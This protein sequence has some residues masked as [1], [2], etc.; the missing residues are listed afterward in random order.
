MKANNLL[1][2]IDRT[3]M[4]FLFIWISFLA[5]VVTEQWRS[6]FIILP[7]AFLILS[8]LFNKEAYRSIFNKAQIPFLAF[9]LSMMAG[10]V[11]VKDP[12]IAHWNFW[13][14]IFPIPFFYLFAK[15][16]FDEKKGLFIIRSVC[17][18]ATLVCAFGIIE[19]VT[20]RN[21]IYELY[22]IH[23]A[24]I[25]ETYYNVFKGRRMMSTH[26]QPAPLGTYLVAILPLAIGLIIRE[27]KRIFK[28][29]A[30][31]CMAVIF[32]S[33]VFTFSRGA[34]LGAFT[35]MSVIA[36]FLAGRKKR[37]FIL[38]L[39]LSVLAIIWGCS[40][41]SGKGYSPFFNR[42]SPQG[43]A[44]KYSFAGKIDR[45]K[46]TGKIL[47]EYPLCGA[48]FGNYRALFDKY[49]PRLA[50]LPNDLKIPD[51]MY[52]AILAETGLIGFGGFSIFIYFLF[53][54]IRSKLRE[55]P[56][57]ENRM[58][59]VIFLSGFLGIMATFL[60]YDGLYWPSPG[61]LFWSYAGILSL[62]SRPKNE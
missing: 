59:L 27:K 51:C 60:T 57:G 12:A 43:L 52:L 25:L 24:P 42:Y 48:G 45:F 38:G 46:M 55:I 47:L 33:I 37:F 21:L 19:L 50:Y 4:I 30:V 3:G 18:M 14:F 28:L 56:D 32:I 7:A 26:I 41:L 36:A 39:V 1:E 5:P 15:V 17:F 61:Y 53:K 10:M 58:F 34:L 40:L 23:R 29:L 11:R 35:V 44:G 20:R 13:S 8:V 6:K 62:L 16:A 49:L 9:L 54:R 2:K 22:L 31:I